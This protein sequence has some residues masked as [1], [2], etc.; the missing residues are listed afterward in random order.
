ML[1]KSDIDLSETST[2]L[3][4]LGFD[5]SFLV[6]TNTALEKSI[7]DAHDSMR[8]F[9][10]RNEIHDYG[11]QIQGQKHY[12]K[13][14]FIAVDECIEVK[15][16]L[17]RPETKK[18]DPRIW[19]YGLKNLVNPF[20]LLAFIYAEGEIYISNCSKDP[21]LSLTKAALPS[22]KIELDSTAEELLEKLKHIS[23]RG[24]IQTMRGGDTGI[25]MTLETLLGIAS[26]S[27]K[28]PDYKGI[29]LKSSR[30][31]QRGSSRNRNQLFSKTPNW[32]LSPIGSA[33]KLIHASG[34]ID[35]D[36]TIELRHTIRGDKPNSLGLY[37]DIDYINDHLLQMFTEVKSSDFHPIHDMTWVL[38][39]LRNALRKKHRETF[40]V[41]AH[42]TFKNESEFFHYVEVVH[43][44][45]PYI[46]RLEMLF[47][48]GIISLDYTLHIK[49]NGRVRDH[50][51]L[52]KLKS[53]SENSLFPESSHYD[54]RK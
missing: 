26:N 54:L 49:E 31:A 38:N 42:R 28:L 30:I 25:G 20:N 3:L 12:L 52:F 17:Y 44:K 27:S 51:Y 1:K 16:S 2:A 13:A 4:N 41:K 22:P 53:N 39:D 23:S 46:D 29:E 19:V 6:P 36:N 35:S 47:E 24:Y 32:K 9:L 43:T 5:V 45:K 8:A 40:W 33:E 21:D 50:G 48:T 11:N 34:Y 18:G 14:K 37:L 10:K 7:I 15:V